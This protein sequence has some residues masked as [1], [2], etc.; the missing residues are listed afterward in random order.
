MSDDTTNERPRGNSWAGMLLPL[1]LAL[2]LA[3]LGRVDWLENQFYDHLQLRQY[4]AASQE[5]LLVTVNPKLDEQTDI[6]SAASML[7]LLQQLDEAGARL[8]AVTQPL[9][10]P[11]M[12]SMEQLRAIRKLGDS[13]GQSTTMDT[14]SLVQTAAI[15]QEQYHERRDVVA[16][17]DKLGNV[18]MATSISDNLSASDDPSRDCTRHAVDVGAEADTRKIATVRNF[19]MP[20]ADICVSFQGIGFNKYAADNDNVVRQSQ[21]VLQGQGM[22]F[23]SLP[24]AVYAAYGGDSGA[25]LLNNGSVEAAGQIFTPTLLNAFYANANGSPV[26]RTLGYNELLS[27]SFNPALIRDRVVLVGEVDYAGVPGYTTPVNANMSVLELTAT[28]VSNLIDNKTIKRPLWLEPLETGALVILVAASLILLPRMPWMASMIAGISAG[29]IL[30]GIE[31]WMLSEQQIWVQLATTSLFVTVSVI[32][33]TLFRGVGYGR[34][35]NTTMSLKT[36]MAQSSTDSLDLEYSVLRQKRPNAI[37]KRKIYDIADQYAETREFAKAE[38]ALRYLSEVDPDY[39]DVAEKLHRI[40]GSKKRKPENGP[41]KAMKPGGNGKQLGRYEII[42]TL[43]RG[44]MSTVYLG[45]DPTIQRKV[46]IKTI[47]LADEFDET[48]LHKARAQFAR[49]AESAGRLNHPDIVGIYD[50]GEHK[51]IAYLAME[52]F[53]GTPLIEFADRSKLLK[54]K[55]V[56]ELIA[57]AAEALDYA[58]GQNVVHR[59][60]KP[61]NIMYDATTDRLK[62]TDF[63]IARLTDTSR[64]KTGVI[65][66][67]PS[68]MSPEQLSASGVTGQS[69]LYSLGV[70][71]YHLLTGAPPFRADSIPQLMDKIVHEDPRPISELRSDLPECVSIIVKK[72]LAKN[73]ADR[74]QNGKAMALALRA[75]REQFAV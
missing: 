20:E 69:D 52:Y 70:T 35:R 73:P 3:V 5:I 22:V 27:G 60:V 9:R 53:S 14:N 4:N 41:D 65:L 74:Y 29:G 21:L 71:L 16:A 55:H 64:T 72:S 18:L 51:N 31:S 2:T 32:V 63:G 37:T 66:G 68:Y 30:V 19:N 42:K 45:I 6:W 61:A 24:L 26:F 13:A 46:A 47:A 54:P 36:L 11:E 10:F 38:Q 67:T 62:I 75:C 39:M 12:V 7:P 1:L 59:D 50:I 15:L 40:S 34:R 57:R 58:H 23:P 43:G 28:A 48:Q 56:M 17:Y 44:A 49:E 33:I 25:K 8:I